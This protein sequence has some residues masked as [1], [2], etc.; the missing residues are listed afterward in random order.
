ME[1]AN[2][3]GQIIKP[4]VMPV[5]GRVSNAGAVKI[6]W[7]LGEPFVQRKVAGGIKVT[8][9]Y[10]QPYPGNVHRIVTKTI[11][12]ASYCLGETVAVPYQTSGY[13]LYGNVFTAQLSDSNGSFVNPVIIGTRFAKTPGTIIATIPGNA[14]VATGYRIRVVSSSPAVTGIE[15]TNELSIVGAP[16]NWYAD[17]DS[18]GFGNASVQLLACAQPAGYVATFGDC[19]DSN[20]LIHPGAIET[21]NGTDDNCN[22][23]TD[24]GFAATEYFVD[25][26]GDHF[27]T[28][29]LGYSCQLLTTA[30]QGGDCDDGSA[31]IYPA[32]LDPSF[33]ISTH[34]SEILCI[35]QQTDGKIIIGGRF[36][37]TIPAP[38]HLMG[39]DRFN[40][41]GTRDLSFNSGTGFLTPNVKALAV[42]PDGK[43][44]VGGG[45]ISYQGVSKRGM[46]RLFS[47]GSRDGGFNSGG[48]HFGSS[49]A[50]FSFALQPDNKII[51]GG[52]FR[53]YNSTAAN[54]LIR[55][56]TD[57]TRDNTFGG[58]GINFDNFSG[59]STPVYALALQ[60][61]GKIIAAG[62]FS[63]Y[64]SIARRCIVRINSDGSID[65]SFN[66]GGGTYDSISGVNSGAIYTS[67]LQPDGKI[68]IGGSF[69][70][71]H[72]TSMNYIARVNIDGSLDTTFHIGTGFETMNAVSNVISVVLQPDRK[73]LV[74]GNFTVYNGSPAGSGMVRLNSDGSRDNT[75]MPT[76]VM[77]P[78]NQMNVLLQLDGKI[79]V[80]TNY[81]G[82]NGFSR[83]LVRLIGCS[84]P[85]TTFYRDA[86][87]DNF[88]NPGVSI[89]AV[90]Q[91]PGYILN[92][93]DC[94][95]TNS[96]IHP[97]ATEICNL[98]DDDC[99]GLIDGADPSITGRSVWYADAD[100]DGYGNPAVF[101]PACTQPAGMVSNNNDCNDAA[102]GIHPGTIEICGNGIDDNCDGQTDEGCSI[103]LNLKVFIEGFYT[104]S[105]QMQAALYINSLSMDTTAC[106]SI[107]I[108]LHAPSSPYDLVTSST[109]LMHTDGSVTV[110]F[111]PAITNH[112]YY[113]VLRQRNAIETW[114][115][116]PILFDSA[117]VNFDFTSP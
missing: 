98:M 92:N 88:G 71:Y 82:S 11:F 35:T 20:P 64:D 48:T 26:D 74:T 49:T 112:E 53:T 105:R 54:N 77:N 102:T 108:E 36:G 93:T 1:V 55:L 65:N 31:A 68:I 23:T 89:V 79:V 60:S 10:H 95:D 111:D 78:Y 13:Y 8:E 47:D 86:D 57:G 40:P 109:V 58:R 46:V 83:K 24:E 39:I 90:N 100:V 30:T 2:L 94:D 28:T 52:G 51:V 6:S 87:G 22:G 113:I 80:G 97:G 4:Q 62:D 5:S 12:P 50:V 27:G 96:S 76:A 73:V 59:S 17:A 72:S 56:N 116:N 44:L 101:T 106:D 37:I 18:D 75:F 91:P 15:N 104:G 45:F 69:R 14:S 16:T 70:Y 34:S 9:G 42:Q 84:D 85:T 33:N 114:S 21:C 41:D 32:G 81:V 107:T 7:T 67:A 117:I 63:T 25:N 103:T 19:N 29:S 115:K 110:Q 66:P 61:D 3:Y 99:D 43:I 38:F